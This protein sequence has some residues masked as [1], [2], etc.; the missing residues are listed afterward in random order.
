MRRRLSIPTLAA[1]LFGVFGMLAAASTYPLMSRFAT[2]AVVSEWIFIAV[3]ALLA[4]LFALLVYRGAEN[5][6][7]SIGQSLSR[8]LLVAILTWTGFSAMA[9]WTWC[10]PVNYGECFRDAL[11][12]SGVLGGGQLLLAALAAAA[13]AGYAIRARTAGNWKA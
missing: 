3:P 2:E 7:R 4:A 6:V 11:M 5:R 1:L 8:G 9:T 12:L 10:I 13:V